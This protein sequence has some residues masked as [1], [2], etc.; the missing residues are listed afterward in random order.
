MGIKDFLLA[1]LYLFIIYQIL[2]LIKKKECTDNILHKYFIPAATAKFV[3]AVALG[4]VY[5]FYY[6]G[7][8]TVI[9]YKGSSIINDIITTK[10]LLGLEVLVRDCKQPLSYELK[11]YFRGYMYIYDN[12]SFFVVRIAAIIGL[13]TFN[14]Y[15]VTSLFF[16]LISFSGSWALF[17][18]LLNIYPHMHKELAYCIFFIPSVIFWGSGI[19]K[20][21]LTFGAIGWFFYAFYHIF[22]Q[23]EI[24]TKKLIALVLSVS[25][26]FMVK[27]YILLA[28][29]PA[30]V[31][32]LF[33]V[34]NQKIKSS[35]TR[36]VMLPILLIASL[37]MGFVAS[38]RIAA[39]DEQYRIEN[40]SNKAKI[41]NDWLSYMSKLDK[42]SYY[43]LGITDYSPAGLIKVFP[44]AVN[45][46]LFRPYLWEARKPIMV[47]A[48]VESLF[49]LFF[50]VFTILKVGFFKSIS[51]AKNNPI[52]PAFLIFSV[53][54]A[55]A[56]GV[57][58]ANFGTLVRYKIPI[59]PF[60]LLSFFILRGGI[61]KQNRM[62]A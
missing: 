1:P 32:W 33:L 8:D 4:L 18:T 27:I 17:R 52:I 25:V 38:S 13:F 6:K 34:Y 53:G 28:L 44:R 15:L 45:V 40:L 20:D 9:F 41:T 48:A 16:S 55:F 22:I 62:R 39:Q 19:L 51:I 58:A 5:F 49:F 37:L 3:G 54:L 21:T 56:V 23:R 10:P 31:V 47:M 11:A 61:K 29:L 35:I 14:S 59:M 36:L 26:L 42:G 60:Y 30:L 50:S 43:D 24:N 2:F 46:T 12:A 7:G 57:T